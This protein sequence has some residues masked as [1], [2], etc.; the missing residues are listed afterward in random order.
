MKQLILTIVL[1]LFT[2]NVVYAAPQLPDQV[3]QTIQF[4]FDWKFS[5]GD[6][7][8]RFGQFLN[9]REWET[10]QLPHDVSIYGP[11]VKE[12]SDAP[13]GWRPRSQGWYRKTFVLP[14]DSRGKKVYIEFEGVYRD[15][16]VWINGKHLG[17][18]LNGY[19]GFEHDLTPHINW[20]G[21]NVIAVHYDNQ[22]SGTSRWYT[23]EG[24]YRD[25]W[26]RIVEPIH[27]PLHGTFVTTP[28]INE[29]SAI[30]DIQ[31]EVINQYPE[32]KQVSI[33]TEI[34]DKQGK[35]VSSGKAVAP[36]SSNET[37]TFCQ[38]L[39]VQKPNLW[40]VDNPYLY[41]VVTKVFDS[42]KLKDTYETSFGIREVRLTPDKGLLLNGKRVFAKGGDIHHDLGCLGAATFKVG[43]RKRFKTLKDMGCNSIRL[44]HN[45]HAKMVLDLCDEM[46]ILVIDELYDK[47]TSQFYGGEA[48]FADMWRNDLENFIRRDRNH[49]SVYI[50]SM[51]NEVLKQQGIWD[52][53]FETPD[54]A[55][56]YGVGVLKQMVDHTHYLDPSRKVT[57][58]LYPLRETGMKE[59]ENW[60]IYDKYMASAPPPMA[61]HMDVVS[62]NY[63]ENLFDLDHKNYPQMMFIASES[64]TNLGIGT[65]NNS[66]L[67]M[68]HSYLIGYY[69]WSAWDYLGESAWPKKTWANAFFNLGE[70]ITTLGT[71]Y[72]AFYSDDP[73]VDISV[74]ETEGMKI[75]QW[76][77]HANRM[78]WSWYPMARHWNWESKEKVKVA[79]FTNCDQ[80]ELFVN[81]Q[82]LGVKK[83]ADFENRLIEWDVPY[84][85]GKIRA[86]ALNNNSKVAE[87]AL[88]TAGRPVRILLEPDRETMK[89]NGLDLAYIKVKLIDEEGTV[90]SDADRPIQFDVKGVAIN[91]GVAN[92]DFYSD[93]PF[94]SNKRSTYEGC[95]LLVIRSKRAKGNVTITATSIELPSSQCMI[96]A[97]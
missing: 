46:G 24:I 48:S 27:V 21:E 87:H 50:W 77:I 47:W 11:F 5:P 22:T 4:N 56:D 95:C 82:S 36:I 37:Y 38:E 25:V 61:F 79:T 65:R 6:S 57:C 2:A 40:D 8:L 53:E 9:D 45:P 7:E 31:T 32:D 92:G 59:W 23:G 29:E 78:R 12:T 93:E 76:K 67:E 68:D 30:V 64:S 20:D 66:W 44:S 69:Y 63:M 62:W 94:Q 71:M 49:P 39:S 90:V 13:N 18:H 52:D 10:V 75:D 96:V 84:Q 28:R 34:V 60:D 85:P 14:D 16:N 88:D 1:C 35:V 15:A 41:R 26:L 55:D 51:G 43:Y 70:E 91:A 19:M 3:R 17:R 80:V 73:F 42:E 58:A 72:R 89:A 83:R 33:A 54:D 97:D 81:G 74:Y 86:V